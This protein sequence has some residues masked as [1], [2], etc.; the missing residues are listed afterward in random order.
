[1]KLMDGTEG[2]FE[3]TGNSREQVGIYKI[4]KKVVL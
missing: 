1:M 2:I 4:D 3:I